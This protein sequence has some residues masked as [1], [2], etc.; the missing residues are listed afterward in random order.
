M[1][2]PPSYSRDQILD[3]AVTAAHRHWRAATVA[4]VTEQLG[5]P[6]GS[7]YHRFGSR[8]ALFASAWIRSVRR[9]HR[10]FDAVAAIEEPVHAMVETALLIPRFCREH[11]E[12]ARMLTVFRYADL[13]AEPPAGLADDL[14]DLNAPVRR[15]LEGLARR[16][17][18]RLSRRGVDIVTLACRDAPM[19]MVRPLI[20]EQV[21]EWIDEAVRASAA[22]VAGL[23]DTVN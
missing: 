14:R 20:G 22:A 15:L 3:A 11:P 4:Q 21:P 19:G 1:P 13:V 5:A 2:K 12:D 17:Y 7:I 8:D 6:S 10:G 16:R 23:D 18:G 9:F